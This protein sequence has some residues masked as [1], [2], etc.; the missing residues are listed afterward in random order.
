MYAR[1]F[2]TTLGVGH[3]RR[4]FTAAELMIA[5][6]ILGTI[7]AFGFPRVAREIRRARV[8]QA[9]SL[10]ASDIEVAFSLAGRQRRPVTVS[11]S[12]ATKELQIAD[13]ASPTT[14]LRRRPLGSDTEWNIE[15]VTTAGLPVTIF[16]SGIA[17]GAFSID[18][19]SG[20]STRRVT[21]TR[22]GLTRVFTP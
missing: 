4:G 11:Y 17:S 18:L 5:V 13:R 19:T 14:V 1:R 7:A 2:T 3:L 12:S 22:V 15:Q 20:A 9:A 6:V 16:P 8:N 10:V 21:A